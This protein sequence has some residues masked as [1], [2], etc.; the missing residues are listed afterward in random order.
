MFL[1]VKTICLPV[2]LTFKCSVI[3]WFHSHFFSGSILFL[4]FSSSAFR[5]K[6]AGINCPDV[7]CLRK[8]VLV[9]KFIGTDQVPAPKLKDAHLSR[10]QLESAYEECTQVCYLLSLTTS[11]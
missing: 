8:H 3:E 5:M 6:E 10:S 7:I 9:M 11:I 2:C 1:A 4:F